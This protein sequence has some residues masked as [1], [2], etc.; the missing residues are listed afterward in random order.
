MFIILIYNSSLEKESVLGAK[1]LNK[2][3]NGNV[4]MPN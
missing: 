2:H 3:A 4:Q 1:I